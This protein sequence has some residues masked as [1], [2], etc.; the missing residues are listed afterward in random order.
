MSFAAAHRWSWLWLGAA[1]CAG[2]LSGCCKPA[3][4][5]REAK[6]PPQPRTV[7]E[8]RGLAS[9]YTDRR[10]ASGERFNATAMCC[11]HRSW[12]MG[13]KV[14]VTHL[15]TGKHVVVRVNDRGPF[16]RGRVIDLTPAAASAIGL[17]RKQGVAK[18]RLERL[19]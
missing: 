7:A 16:T 13:T 3:A 10:T 18:V 12:P 2:S 19:H 5:A 14:R 6:L 9:I 4:I 17:T 1:L 15:R 11:A 8:Q